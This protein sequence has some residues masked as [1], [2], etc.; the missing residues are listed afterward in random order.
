MTGFEKYVGQ[1]LA[2]YQDGD[3]GVAHDV[4][5]RIQQMYISLVSALPEVDWG[6]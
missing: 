1:E 5:D 3:G 6:A 2:Q 4:L